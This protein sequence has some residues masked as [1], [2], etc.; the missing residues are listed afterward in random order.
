MVLDPWGGCW[1]VMLDG[2][3]WHRF[4]RCDRV[5]AGGKGAA[6]QGRLPVPERTE[7]WRTARTSS[8]PSLPTTQGN[9]SSEVERDL[10][11]AGSGANPCV[12][13]VLLQ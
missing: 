10:A 3:K 12:Y 5:H 8:P 1:Q 13:P 6:W 9:Q 4:W 2:R 7:L 11:I